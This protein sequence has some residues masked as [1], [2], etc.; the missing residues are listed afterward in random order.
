VILFSVCAGTIALAQQTEVAVE[1]GTVVPAGTLLACTLD[2]PNFS[3]RTTQIGDPVLCHLKSI[4]MFGRSLIPRGAY[5]SARLQDYRDPGHF[6]GKGWLQLEFTSLTLPHGNLPLNAKVISADHYRVD[7]EGKIKGHGHPTRDVVEW[8]IPILWPMKVLTLPARGPRPTLKG[9]TRIKLRLM[10]DIFVPESASVAPNRLITKSSASL[11]TR[12]GS[13]A[14]L[15]RQATNVFY[16]DRTL[17]VSQPMPISS[18]PIAQYPARA[19]TNQAQFGK[20]EPLL[21]LLALKGGR[22]YLVLDYWVDNWNLEF[23]TDLGARQA[24]PL[25][26]FDFP[27]TERLNAE[28]GLPFRLTIYGH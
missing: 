26:D 21:T 9:E 12:E 28:R 3:S 1:N 20:T 17:P 2:E 22:V 7:R 18:T 14:S 11:P 5:L 16:R 19:A 13:D 24:V 15:T 23:T 27:L 8:T 10:D 4:E 6:F 25:E